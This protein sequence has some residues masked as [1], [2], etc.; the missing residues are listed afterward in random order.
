MILLEYERAQPL[1]QA[2]RAVN[3]GQGQGW[4]VPDPIDAH[5]FSLHLVEPRGGQE[6]DGRSWPGSVELHAWGLA[7]DEAV[8]MLASLQAV[9]AKSETED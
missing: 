2:A 4:L 8:A 6:G 9:A 1:E 3:I 5:K 7:L